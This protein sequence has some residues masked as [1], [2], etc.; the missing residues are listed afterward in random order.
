MKTAAVTPDSLC[1]HVG[2]MESLNGYKLSAHEPDEKGFFD[3]V[4]GCFGV[5]TRGRVIYDPQS[6]INCM[7]DTSSRF[8]IC[9]RDGNLCGEYG[10]PV[11]N[12]EKDMPRLFQIDEHYKSHYFGDI[13]TGEPIN[14][15]GM[16]AIPIKAKVKPTGPYGEILE[17]ELRD[18]C[19]NTSFSIR[20]L[21]LPMN[22]P[23][24][25]YEYR[26]VQS[27]ITFDAVHAPGFDITSKRYVSATESFEEPV[28]YTALKKVTTANVGMESLLIDER[29][30]KRITDEKDIYCQ[31]RHF[32]S[33][34]LR[35]TSY[36]GEDGNYHNIASL[37]YKRGR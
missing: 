9:L 2:I 11:I 36:L 20:S 27:V 13:K 7:K 18:P 31:G 22:G 33:A 12:T 23:N 15:N 1:F 26:K 17:K 35:S 4:V 3:V 6:L 5:P 37:A 28:S 21:C 24:P 16:E 32:G 10:H 30:V 34:S 14:I 19:H 29:D 8:N 25:E